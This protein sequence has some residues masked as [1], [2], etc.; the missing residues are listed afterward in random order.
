MDSGPIQRDRN[1]IGVNDFTMASVF[2]TCG[3]HVENVSGMTPKPAQT[4][5]SH[6]SPR[7]K[8]ATIAERA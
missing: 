3:K 7:A 1:P 4:Q 5:A 8:S 2:H 6:D